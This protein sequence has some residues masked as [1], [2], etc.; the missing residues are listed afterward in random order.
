MAGMVVLT[1]AEVL[2]GAVTGFCVSKIAGSYINSNKRKERNVQRKLKK[3]KQKLAENIDVKIDATIEQKLGPELVGIAREL[4]LNHQERHPGCEAVGGIVD[5]GV[6]VGVGVANAHRD[7]HGEAKSS[8]SPAAA[9]NAADEDD[10]MEDKVHVLVWIMIF[11]VGIA[12]IALVR[13]KQRLL[14]DEREDKTKKAPQG[15]K[16]HS[17]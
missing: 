10:D 5:G 7:L 15:T 1:G 12:A 17:S 2:F 16:G 3:E 13:K 14:M 4:K 8:A 11:F 9:G 6:G